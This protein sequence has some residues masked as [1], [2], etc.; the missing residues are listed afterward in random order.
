M[1]TVCLQI[2]PH[3]VSP[4]DSKDLAGGGEGF[5]N[6]RVKWRGRIVTIQQ[7]QGPRAQEVRLISLYSFVPQFMALD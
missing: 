5:K 3:E 1:T 7:F 4:L 6:Y 2:L